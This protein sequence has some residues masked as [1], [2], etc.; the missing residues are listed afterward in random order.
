MHREKWNDR[1]PDNYYIQ[2]L[3]YLLAT[4]WD[5]AILKAQL[6]TVYSDEV[7]LNTGITS[8]N[9]QMFRKTWITS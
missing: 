2:C 4:G 1:I 3:H 7:R 5:F 8:L 6:K 9:G